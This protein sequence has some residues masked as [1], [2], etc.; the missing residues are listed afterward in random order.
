[1]ETTGSSIN[2]VP[3]PLTPCSTIWANVRLRIPCFLGNPP[4]FW[5][6]NSQ[7]P[8]P[9]ITRN[10]ITMLLKISNSFQISKPVSSK[11]Q[12]FQK[13]KMSHGGRKSVKKVSRIWPQCIQYLSIARFSKQIGAVININGYQRLL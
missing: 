6:S 11:K 12:L 5:S 1:M 8:R 9:R 2:D 4:V 13:C 7:N 10:A 3:Q